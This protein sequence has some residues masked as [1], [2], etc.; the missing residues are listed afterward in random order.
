MMSVPWMR[1]RLPERS[2]VMMPI[3][4]FGDGDF[5]VDDGFEKHGAGFGD[6]VAEGP[7]AGGFEGDFF[8]VDRM[9]LAV[10]DDH[11][12]ILDGVAGDGAGFEH[13]ADAF[14]DC[15]MYWPGMVPPKTSSTNSKP[16]AAIERL[17]AE[18]DFAELAGAAGLLFVAV[19]AFGGGAD[20]FLVG[21]FGGLGVDHEAAAFSGA[22]GAGAGAVR[23]GR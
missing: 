12:D 21:D 22:P 19:M 15:G 20:G 4:V 11:A 14:F 23:P 17:D 1:P 7:F 9:V 13:F 5:H 18:I 3:V 8:A 2:P 10:V 16:F 6:G